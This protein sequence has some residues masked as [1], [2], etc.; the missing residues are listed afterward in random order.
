MGQKM[1]GGL[2]VFTYYEKLGQKYT[3]IYY[4]LHK[5]I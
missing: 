2:P 4:T 1:K 3:L 5:H